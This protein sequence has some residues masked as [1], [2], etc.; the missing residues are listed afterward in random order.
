MQ[1][2]LDAL[3]TSDPARAAELIRVMKHHLDRHFRARKALEDRGF[4]SVGEALEHLD[5][6]SDRVEALEAHLQR[7]KAPAGAAP[8]EATEAGEE[9]PHTR[10]SLDTPG[11]HALFEEVYAELNDLH[12]ALN[13][14]TTAEALRT[15]Q[16]LSADDP[17]DA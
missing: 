12:E 14:D 5:A 1:D 13:A 10:N 8:V 2:V 16:T 9:T 11:L 17:P 6:L 7:K 3:N 4:S 15:I